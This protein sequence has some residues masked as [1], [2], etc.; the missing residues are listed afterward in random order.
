MK[1]L[2]VEA[3]LTTGD[4][5]KKLHK[6]AV[7]IN[8]SNIKAV[9][10]KM[11][12]SI[13]KQIIDGF[14][15]A[16]TESSAYLISKLEEKLQT[17]VIE[18]LFS[19]SGIGISFVRT[20]IGASD[21]SLRSFTYN[22]LDINQ[23]DESLN[24]FSLADDLNY[25]I[26]VLKKAKTYQDFLIV[27]SP[28]SAPAWMKDNQSLNGGHLLKQYYPVYANYLV[29]FIQSYQAL[30]LDIY[31]ITPQN[32]PRHESLNY[33]S[34]LM[35]AID[36][37][38]FIKE[39]GQAVQANQ[40]QSKIIAYDHNWDDI[41]YAKTILDDEES[42]AFVSGTGFHCYDG[43]VNATQTLLEQYP[44]KDIWFTECS[45]GLWAPNFSDNLGWNV[46]NVF[47]GSLNHGAKSVLLWNIALDLECGPKNGGCMNCRGLLTIDPQT[48]TIERNVEYYLV[49]HFS[50]FIKKGAYVIDSKVSQQHVL[51]T[52]FLNPDGS[53]ICVA[54]NQLNEPQFIHLTV[55]GQT[56]E[57]ELKEKSLVT[58][59]IETNQS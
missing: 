40:I 36:Q 50:K 5:S 2:K 28:W 14:G 49:A 41:N 6:E 55:L 54:Y 23:T 32:E 44:E 45:G 3:Y 21:F 1:Q 46:E 56:V 13:K 7:K 20:T 34:M 25:V 59:K 48:K 16:M 57:F 43:N 10:I 27:S 4:E 9:E 31:A 18:D 37:R 51:T 8:K 11:D 39:L 29:K 26:P 12:P 17:A 53:L 30:G 52:S 33:P 24:Q 58:F 47:I 19:D 35:S 15:A 22:D 42:A 38:E